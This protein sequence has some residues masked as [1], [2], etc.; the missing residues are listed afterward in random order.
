MLRKSGARFLEDEYA[1]TIGGTLVTRFVRIRI[2]M[3][4]W[5]MDTFVLNGAISYARL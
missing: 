2:S 1:G 4:H 5:R 3:L